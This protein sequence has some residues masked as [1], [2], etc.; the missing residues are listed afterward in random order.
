MRATF[1]PLP[2][3]PHPPRRRISGS[4]F[5]TGRDGALETIEQEVSYLKG[6]DVVI[7]VVVDAEHISFSGILK[8]D[9]WRKLRHRGAEVSFDVPGRGRLVFFTDA[10]D[11][12]VQNLRA[13]GLGL[14]ALRAVDRYG[15][16][17]SAEQ[18]AGFAML[19]PGGPDPARG[20]QLVDAAGG[21]TQAL[22][23]HHPDRGGDERD[24]VDVQ[25]YRQ[26]VG[27]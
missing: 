15:I 1:R 3:W 5:R 6:G 12:V 25:A 7:G 8:A 13:I 16:T 11:D 9:G 14:E 19:A 10:Y 18:Y 21:L 24:F 17:S 22:K 20:K 23:K 2:T 27:A 4:R 26:Q